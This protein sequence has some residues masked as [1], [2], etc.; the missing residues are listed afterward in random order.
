MSRCA[1]MKHS[2]LFD[3]GMDNVNVCMPLI[4]RVDE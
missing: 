1:V 3:Y 2:V 4:R